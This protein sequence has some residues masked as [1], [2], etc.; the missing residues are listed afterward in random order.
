VPTPIPTKDGNPNYK[1]KS[2]AVE[3]FELS[4]T[5][6]RDVYEY[7]LIV[8]YEV[9]SVNILAKELGINA[10]ID[11]AGKRELAVGENQI[12]VKVTA[13]NGDVAIYKIIIHRKENNP[14]Y[15]AHLGIE[16]YAFTPFF[17]TDVFEYTLEVPFT[18]EKVKIDA[19][20]E[21]ETTTVEGAGEKELVIGENVFEIKTKTAD[22]LECIYKITITRLNDVVCEMPHYSFSEDSKFVYG[23]ILG[24]TIKEVKAEI[25]VTNGSFKLV[26]KN[27]Q[28][29]ADDAVIST[30][31]KIQ[32]LDSTDT[33]KSEVT[34]CIFGDINGDGKIDLIDY[35]Y[36]KKYLWKKVI[37]SEIQIYALDVNHSG[38]V[39]LI[40][41]VYLKKYTWGK[42][43]ISQQRID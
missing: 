30:G 12:S 6:D 35:V 7:G 42:N 14:S 19:V 15:L 33:L 5:F 38:L 40:D 18:Q 43:D 13:E 26:D 36:M 39:D 41:R 17:A 20:A 34:V 4:P 29:L 22:G 21:V 16:G 25:K 8:D 27:G 32:I 1:L 10:V 24:Q 2:L 9:S 31:Q 28:E 23:F 11:G 37:L 3:G